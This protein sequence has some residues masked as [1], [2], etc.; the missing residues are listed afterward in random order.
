ML[1]HL[2]T[3]SCLPCLEGFTSSEGES[4]GSGYHRLLGGLSGGPAAADEDGVTGNQ[5]RGWRGKEE[6][7]ARNV[8]RLADSV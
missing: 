5:R 6:Y 7:S 2:V 1:A 3:Y 8:H 4:R